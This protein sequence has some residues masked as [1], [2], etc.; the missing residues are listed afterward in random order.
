LIFEFSKLSN[1]SQSMCNVLW[2]LYFYEKLK[3]HD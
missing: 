1:K 2:L 3:T